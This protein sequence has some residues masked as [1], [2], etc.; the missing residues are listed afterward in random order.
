MTAHFAEKLSSTYLQSQQKALVR[1]LFTFLF[2]LS[3]ASQVWL[4]DRG[5]GKGCRD[6]RAVSVRFCISAYISA[7]RR[8]FDNML[9]R[10]F[11]HL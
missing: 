2:T 1:G 8:A 7:V 5:E 9:L 11:F 6:P 4:S 10:S 3:D